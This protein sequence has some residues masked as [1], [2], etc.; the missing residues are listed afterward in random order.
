[1]KHSMSGSAARG[2]KYISDKSCPHGHFERYI[3]RN[4][5]VECES[6]YRAVNEKRISEQREKN[7]EKQ[8]AWAAQ[9]YVKHREELM[10]KSSDYYVA[11]RAE[12]CTK[13]QQWRRNNRDKCNAY[14]GQYRAA[15]LNRTPAWAN[16]F[17]MNEA[18]AL[19]QL[20]TKMTGIQWHV[21][22]IIPLRGKL[23]SGLHVENNLQVITAT[24]NH[25][26]NNSFVVNA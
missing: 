26:K 20:R 12:A 15:K 6:Q 10:R 14:E 4:S 19:S 17:F 8:R 25:K 13:N 5:C 18:Y 22:H 16:H 2:E 3:N 23:I 7:R 11:N 1:M 21:D 24:E 9:H